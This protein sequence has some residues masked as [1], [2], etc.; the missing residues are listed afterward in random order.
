V[1][2]G[3]DKCPLLLQQPAVV[4]ALF[5]LFGLQLTELVL[6]RGFKGVFSVLFS[7]LRFFCSL[8]SCLCLGVRKLVI[9]ISYLVIKLPPL[10]I[11]LIA[12]LL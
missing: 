6:D 8:F 1:V 3:L 5:Q 2:K 9:M 7:L 12:V 10:S 11:F 4:I